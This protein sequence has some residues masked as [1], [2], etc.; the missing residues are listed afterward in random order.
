MKEFEGSKGKW[1]ACCLGEG[2]TSHFVFDAGEGTICTMLSNDPNDKE[3]DFESMAGI[4]TV[5]ERQA[6]ARLIASAPE[7]LEA[8]QG[9]MRIKD[10]WVMSGDVREE[11][12]GEAIA[13]DSMHRL[14]E[15][16][17][18]KALNTKN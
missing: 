17:I 6:N 12:R 4:I 2:K 9:A 8:L 10:L 16:A 5:A 14:F 15:Q 11:H 13:L 1:H 3:S 18:D 7:L